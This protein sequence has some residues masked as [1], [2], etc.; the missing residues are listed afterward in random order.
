MNK[1]EHVIRQLSASA[2]VLPQIG[3]QYGLVKKQNSQ[4]I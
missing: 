4:E 2:K 3:S 1:G